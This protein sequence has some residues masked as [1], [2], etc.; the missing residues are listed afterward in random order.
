MN[1]G[2]APPDA[3]GE[4]QAA[5]W[6]RAMF[7][8]VA[9]RYDLLN[10]LL[11]FQL[12][13][14]WRARTVRLLKTPLSDPAARV[15]DICCGSGDLTFALRRGGRARVYGA[16]FCRPMLIEAAAKASRA[17]GFPP[18]FEADALRLP[19]QDRSLDVITAAFGFRNL[20][21]Y[22]AGLA[23]MRRVLKPGGVAA[24]LEFTQPPGR[25]VRAFYDA[26]SRWLL[27]SIGSWI[28]GDPDA[29]R[30]LPDS[31]RRFPDAPRLA[32]EM[33]RAGFDS[34]AYRYFTCGIVALHV[35]TVR[36]IGV[37]G[38]ALHALRTP[39]QTP[40]RAAA[41]AWSGDASHEE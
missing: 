15:L 27:P 32:G 3:S 19:V 30:Y 2:A 37:S 7:A 10:H 1:R 16:D 4:E 18:L 12:D 29:Y 33:K 41:R 11:S 5:R 9:P 39:G 35:G 24:I 25:V 26:Y 8:R 17:D 22:R 28:S 34:V 14:R 31:I 20:A 40:G 38:D 13:R 6:V 23:E 21:N 36:E